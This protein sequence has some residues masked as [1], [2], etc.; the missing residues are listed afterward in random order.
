MASRLDSNVSQVI[1]RM[2]A[3]AAKAVRETAAA[4]ETDVKTG[5][6]EPKSGRTYRRK[7]G[8]TH[9]AS[10]P[11]ESPAIGHSALVNSVAAVPVDET[12]SAVGSSHETAPVLELGGGRV[13][14][15]P[16]LGPAFERAAEGFEQRLGE[17]FE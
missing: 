1:A 17:I 10:A 7:G 12:T 9:Q 16:F 15:R 5:M 2:R 13:A 6:A 11:G 14:A 8:K 3:R 4:I